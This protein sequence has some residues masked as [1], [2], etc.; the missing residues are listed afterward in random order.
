M[1]CIAT[2]GD[3]G[4][5]SIVAGG[6]ELD[7]ATAGLQQEGGGDVGGLEGVDQLDGMMDGMIPQFDGTGDDDDEEGEEEMEENEE[8]GG[9]NEEEGG[10]NEEEGGDNED[11]DVDDD[12]GQT[13]D[14]EETTAADEN[15]GEGERVGTR[16]EGMSMAL[17]C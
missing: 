10:E 16:R 12:E 3:S 11:D 4:D 17:I 2:G 9:D 15:P 7:A 13:G 14:S 6:S 1:C 8:E 5:Q